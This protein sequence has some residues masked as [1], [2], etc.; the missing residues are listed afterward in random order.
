[1]NLEL[2]GALKE[3]EKERGISKDLLIEAIETAIISAYKKNYGASSSSSA[4]VELNE[5]SGD[6]RV[7][8][9]RVVVSE[10]QDDTAEIALEEAQALDPNYAL[11]DIVEHEVTPANFG[12]IAAQTAK[13]V[14]I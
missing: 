2:I 5:Q 14:V 6:I 8:S 7:Y 12:R 1:M 4:R 10:V 3:L 11:G 9:R 13:Q